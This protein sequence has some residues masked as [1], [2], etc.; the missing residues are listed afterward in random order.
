MKKEHSE[1]RANGDCRHAEPGDY[2][3]R[4]LRLCGR[5]RLSQWKTDDW[6][7]AT[8]NGTPILKSQPGKSINVL[9]LKGK[10]T[11]NKLSFDIRVDNSFG[12]V[13]GNVGSAFKL[14]DGTQY[15]FEYNTVGELVRIRRLGND[16]SDSHVCPGKSYKLT[17]E[18][19]HTVSL[20]FAENHLLWQI[21]GETVHELSE[22]GNDK[23]EGGTLYI[24]SYN[25]D[26][27]LRNISVESVYIPIVEKRE[28]DFEFTSEKS[29]ADFSARNGGVT[30]KNG[31][32]IYT[33][34]GNDSTLTSPP[35]SVKQGTAYSALL[36]LRNTVLIRMS[37]GTDAS[38]IRL[39]YTT[40]DDPAYT[41]DKSVVLDV[42]PRSG[43]T[44]YY[45]NLSACRNLSGYLYGFRLEPIGAASGS[46]EIEAVTLNVR[47]P[48]RQCRQADLLYHR[49][50]NR[51]GVRHAGQRIR[52]Q[53]S[54]AVR[55]KTGKL[56]AG[57]A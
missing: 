37:N 29:V 20:E 18:Q 22:T 30:W 26:V 2:G 36:P 48:D 15:F 55:N 8:E 27:S 5:K 24:Q 1:N 35:I 17:A 45:F 34:T 25:T 57:S 33:L 53:R 46:I 31:R 51:Y 23:F 54:H 44:T 3:C 43:D 40:T 32:L 19:W 50:Q 10:A 12:T 13:D 38:R 21:D 14:S 4:L 9:Y 52:R 42:Q 11:G 49:R 7:E 6:T 39:S 41:A 56:S 47:L 28:Y 16:G